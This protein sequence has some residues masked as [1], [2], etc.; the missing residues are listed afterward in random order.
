MNCCVDDIGL[1]IPQLFKTLCDE[2]GVLNWDKHIKLTSSWGTKPNFN[3]DVDSDGFQDYDYDYA[4]EINNEEILFTG[5]FE[6]HRRCDC[7]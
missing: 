3:D 5:V 1:D 2:V 4:E 6:S 7:I